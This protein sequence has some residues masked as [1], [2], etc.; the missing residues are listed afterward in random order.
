M[1]EYALITG[2]SSGLGSEFARGFARRGIPSIL[3]ARSEE[4]LS[5]LSA[6]LRRQYETESTIMP[7]DLTVSANRTRLSELCAA[8]SFTITYLVN[9]AGYGSLG[10]FPK[11]ELEH[12]I[13]MTELNCIALQELCHSFARVF[14]RNKKG[15]IINISSTAG[16]QP[17]PY[18]ATYAATKAFVVNFSLALH[19]ELRG[20]GVKVIT[21]CPG[22]I[23]TNF[24]DNAGMKRPPKYLKVHTPTF[25]VDKILG[26]IDS[27]RSFIIPG[28]I[29]KLLYFSS[30]LAPI[31]VRAWIASKMF[32]FKD[33]SAA[34]F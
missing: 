3:V 29:N 8:D 15:T 34:E 12:E 9:S 27:N 1:K 10:F 2:A 16:F 22:P 23:D 30:G 26:A 28:L 14:L 19:N 32:P 5:R 18:M 21:V 4:K 24:F 25:V 33:S 13:R 6:E 7:L 11:L 17:I 31:L 20:T